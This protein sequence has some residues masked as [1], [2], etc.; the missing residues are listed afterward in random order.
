V[1]VGECLV[2]LQHRELGIVGPVHALVAEVARELVDPF[3]ATDD[4]P[5]EVQ[6]VRDAQ[7]EVDAEGVVLRDE[8][9]RKCA[10]VERLQ[11]RGLDLEEPRGLEPSRKAAVR[12]A[13]LRKISRTSRFMNRSA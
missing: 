12:R 1:D 2:E 10:A 11:N 7:V 6:L 4:E 3:Q 9:T 13:R 5:L 8:W